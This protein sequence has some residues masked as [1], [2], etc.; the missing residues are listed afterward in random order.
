MGSKDVRKERFKAVA[1]TVRGIYNIEDEQGVNLASLESIKE[2]LLNL[3]NKHALFSEGHFIEGDDVSNVFYRLSEDVDHKVFPLCN[4]YTTGKISVH[5][6]I[7]LGLSSLVLTGMGIFLSD[8]M[9]HPR[10]G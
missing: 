2:V 3:A 1:K 10:M 8:R 9:M 4:C 6:I 5:T 7:Q